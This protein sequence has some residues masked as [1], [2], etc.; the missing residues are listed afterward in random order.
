M[1][2]LLWLNSHLVLFDSQ[3]A[4]V[5]YSRQSLL[6]TRLARHGLATCW[7]FRDFVLDVSWVQSVWL[8]W[9]RVLC[10]VSGCFCTADLWAWSSSEAVLSE[11][12]ETI[13]HI[14]NWASSWFLY[15]LWQE[16]QSRDG[17]RGRSITAMLNIVTGW[18]LGSSFPAHPML[19]RGFTLHGCVWCHGRRPPAGL[20]PQFQWGQTSCDPAARPRRLWMKP[21]SLPLSMATIISNKEKR[22][23]RPLSCSP[24][25]RLPGRFP[26]WSASV[27][28]WSEELNGS[29]NAAHAPHISLMDSDTGHLSGGHESTTTQPELFHLIHVCYDA[30]A[31]RD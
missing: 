18:S 28:R 26:L 8:L 29:R 23:A 19:R 22:R 11:P 6:F 15:N 25:T 14:W 16:G 13:T 20:S 31:E 5:V 7:L 3:H 1:F 30:Q 10:S 21:S 9:F 12:T 4:W 24:C 27:P 17:A 2:V